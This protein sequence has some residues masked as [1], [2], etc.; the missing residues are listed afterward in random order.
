[1]NVCAPG[2]MMWLGEYAVLA[3]AP[4]VVAAV[5]RFA[6]VSVTPSST[7][8]HIFESMQFCPWAVSLAA[9][10]PE[11][12]VAPL[13]AELVAAVLSEVMGSAPKPALTPSR[14]QLDTTELRATE[15]LGLGSSSALAVALTRALLPEALISQVEQ[16]AIRAH[17]AF[18]LGRGSGSDVLAAVHGGLLV[19]SGGKAQP[20]AMPSDMWWAA[21][22][23]GPGADTRVLIDQV[24][25][26]RDHA[27]LQSSAH[28]SE[29]N[30]ASELGVAALEAGDTYAWLHAVEYFA[31]IEAQIDRASR[32]GIFEGG[33]R[34]AVAAAE[35][36]GWVAK[37]SG[38]G[39]GDVVVAFGDRNAD[40]RSLT[41][42][43]EALGM[44]VLN[45]K[46]APHG[47]VMDTV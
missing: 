19:V 1:M 30:V 4:A 26:W 42:H 2:K 8:E 5:D 40:L 16:V 33:I 27:P 28:F 39:G 20:V 37:P 32:A 45:V 34:E 46:L 14:V 13:G 38:A 25:L 15:K 9:R 24:K 10:V 22:A 17:R 3:G 6:R 11:A 29:L 12:F 18:Q 23:V 31:T 21:I 35:T 7:G 44:S 47:V 36:A 43:V 41:H